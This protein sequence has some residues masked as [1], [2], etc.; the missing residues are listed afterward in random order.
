M[1]KTR[2]FGMRQMGVLAL[3]VLLLGGGTALAANHVIRPN[4]T[5]TVGDG[6]EFDLPPGFYAPEGA[7]VTSVTVE[8]EDGEEFEGTLEFRQTIGEDGTTRSK[9]S[10][11]D[12]ITWNLVDA[13]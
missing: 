6:A 2:K 13:E 4:V 10:V 12:G 1:T 3:C 7:E 11:D 8:A 5:V 9:Y